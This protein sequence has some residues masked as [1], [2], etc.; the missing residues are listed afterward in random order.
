MTQI[1]LRSQYEGLRTAR[2]PYIRAAEE[3]AQYTIPALFVRDEDEVYSG[4]TPRA[5]FQP[6]QSIGATGINGLA[7]SLLLAVFPSGAPFFRLQLDQAALNDLAQ[8]IPDAQA[9]KDQKSKLEQSLRKVEAQALEILEAA[10]VRPIVFEMLRQSL[11]AQVLVYMDPE[12]DRMRVFKLS[13]YVNVRDQMGN[14]ILYIT[15]EPVD[16]RTLD[17]KILEEAKIKLEDIAQQNPTVAL[18]V[19]LF[20]CIKRKSK[21]KWE[22]VQEI[23]GEILESTRTTY[24][25]DDLPY[26][27]LAYSRIPG[28][29]YGRGYV[30]QL[31]GDLRAVNGLRQ[32]VVEGSMISARTIFMVDPAST[33]TPEQ[34]V[35]AR[36]GGFVRGRVGEVT[37]LRVDKGGDYSVAQN[38]EIAIKSDLQLAFMSHLA[39]RRD[40]ERVTKEEFASIASEIDQTLGGTFSRLA[41]ELQ[42]PVAR[43]T[44][45]SMKKK[46]LV[47]NLKEAGVRPTIVTG[48][49][50]LGRGTDLNRLK[51]YLADVQAN[52]Q[53][54]GLETLGQGLL[55]D[56]VRLRLAN[57]HGINAQGLLKSEED[58]QAENQAAQQQQQQQLQQEQVVDMSKTA[59]A[60]P[61]GAQMVGGMMEQLAAQSGQLGAA[62]QQATL[63]Q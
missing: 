34:L 40:A 18:R 3:S 5:L 53:T 30:E 48:I 9:L 36:N 21:N 31:L 60:N 29:A 41:V 27:D 20:T 50:A 37:P 2:D 54:P 7:T 26:F 46:G 38:S 52:S 57:G 13:Q 15:K 62:P 4:E 8:E 51:G 32:A 39:A 19:P 35:Q 63:Q 12:T 33:T 42:M 61:E 23:N 43:L 11:I 45:K 58:I 28:E 1:S 22:V 6:S 47:K 17:E 55:V 59:M 49:A 24:S 14:A 56:E 10:E 16:P 25:N 44:L